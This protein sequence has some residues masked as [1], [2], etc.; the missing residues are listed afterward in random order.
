MDELQLIGRHGESVSFSK[1]VNWNI[2]VK[3]Q[4]SDRLVP[5]KKQNNNNNNADNNIK[6][7]GGNQL[8]TTV[9]TINI[10]RAPLKKDILQSEAEEEG[11]EVVLA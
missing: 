3:Q 2:V 1:G 6:S 8:I 5:R 9:N 11:K 10:D 7:V 4:K